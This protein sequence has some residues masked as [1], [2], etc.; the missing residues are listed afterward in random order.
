MIE[1]TISDLKKNEK[2]NP[3]NETI[4]NTKKAITRRTSLLT[5][6]HAKSMSEKHERNMSD[7]I[8]FLNKL[9]CN[10]YLNKDN[11]SYTNTRLEKFMEETKLNINKIDE[12]VKCISSLYLIDL[13]QVSEVKMDYNMKNTIDMIKN[14][15]GIHYH[16]FRSYC[17]KNQYN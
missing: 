17:P 6:E 9:E 11:L 7:A 5:F 12:N 2:S 1:E 3:N 14:L 13:S 10:N 8:E 16:L 4:N 15:N